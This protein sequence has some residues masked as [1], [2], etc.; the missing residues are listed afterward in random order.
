[1]KF[2]KN[3]F[4]DAIKNTFNFKGRTSQAGFCIPA[5]IVPIIIAAFDRDHPWGLLQWILFVAMLTFTLSFYALSLRG[6]CDFPVSGIWRIVPY[7]M[8]TMPVLYFV[9]FLNRWKTMCF[10][11]FPR[12]IPMRRLF[13]SEMVR[14]PV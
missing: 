4:A 14:H 1:M 3:V 5:L 11:F 13:A 7:F 10:V 2:L 9:L 12:V 8:V 6:A